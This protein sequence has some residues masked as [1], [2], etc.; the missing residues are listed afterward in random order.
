[1]NNTIKF[2]VFSDPHYYSKKNYVDGNPFKNKQKNNQQYYLG[3]EEIIKTAFNEVIADDTVN[4][5]LI[6]GDLVWNGERTS[7]AEMIELL[8]ELK[9]KGKRVY[10]TTATHD[11]SKNGLS[12]GF[13]K[14]NNQVDVPAPYREE[15]ADMYREFGIDEA[16]A[17]NEE[18]MSYVVK[19]TDGYRLLALNDDMDDPV[20]GYSDTCFEWIKEQLKK[21]REDNQFVIA[22]THHPLIPASK[23]YSIIAPGAM[24]YDAPKRINQF[25]EEGLHFMITGHSH[26]H[27]ISCV[28][29]ENGTPFYAISTGSVIGFPPVYRI[30]E[31]S[32]E[33]NTLDISTR[34]VKKV[35]ELDTNGKELPEFIKDIFLGFVYELIDSCE[36]DYEKFVSLT[37]TEFSMDENIARKH[38]KIIQKL[39]RFVNNLTYGKVY[40]ICKKRSGLTKSEVEPI[41]D[42]KVVP[43]II[44]IAANLFKGNADCPPD[45]PEY[46]IA[47]GVLESADKLIRPFSS[48][49]DKKIGIKDVSSIILPLIYNDGIDDYNAVINLN[50]IAK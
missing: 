45:S 25:A 13:D 7:H 21:A 35:D 34:T 30:I 20:C 12:Y 24:L 47:K 11:Y 9:S 19:L 2:A 23:L 48:L 31:Y 29:A 5:V 43:F 4:I 50:E 27:N 16:I 10:V 38:K 1:M 26:I 22:M 32:G 3:S 8:R 17:Y 41:K 36:N 18:T 40:K 39:F 44:D 14:N 28:T 49:L 33:D 46:K 15:L 6:N 42:K 37:N